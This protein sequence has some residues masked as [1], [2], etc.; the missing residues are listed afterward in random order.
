MVE[1]K[2]ILVEK[3]ALIETSLGTVAVILFKK[4]VD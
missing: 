3:Q 1:E 2:L 4:K